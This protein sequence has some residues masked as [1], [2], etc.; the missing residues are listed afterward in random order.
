VGVSGNEVQGDHSLTL[1][2][3]GLT[4]NVTP[5]NG[6]AG[7]NGVDVVSPADA[8]AV[9]ELLTILR[10]NGRRWIRVASPPL[11]D[12][13]LHAVSA[14]SADD[15]W[16]AGASPFGG[17]AD[18]ALLEHWDGSTVSVVA[19]APLTADSSELLG[20]DA[21]ASNDV[22]AVGNLTLGGITS[23]LVEHFDGTTW[24][25]VPAP[26][27]GTDATVLSAVSA[28]GSHDVLAVGSATVAA[29]QHALV[30]RWNGTAWSVVTVQPAAGAPRASLAGV[31]V[32]GAGDAW[33]VGASSSTP[34]VTAPLIED[35][36]RACGGR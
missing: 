10:W 13:D 3:D 26:N 35:A 32:D 31:T 9:G 23:G 16:I 36:E 25:V 34:G 15:V 2:W 7:L 30:E 1:R 14:A 6:L 12:G 5:N 24:S 11:G 20:I 28:H 22:W 21:L 4:W 27:P 33:A 19:G 8:W 29:T 18:Q 17:A